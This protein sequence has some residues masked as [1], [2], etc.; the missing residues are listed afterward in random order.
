MWALQEPYLEVAQ[1]TSHWP[2][3]GHDLHQASNA[4][5][6]V[7]YQRL[8]VPEEAGMGLGGGSG[9]KVPVSAQSL[10]APLRGP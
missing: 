5:Q 10:W 1:P 9:P 7:F 8:V 6:V 2:G 3:P 4:S